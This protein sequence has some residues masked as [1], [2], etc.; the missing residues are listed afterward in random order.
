MSE[1]PYAP[2]SSQVA[3]I[4]GDTKSL[5]RPRLVQ[6]GIGL[7]AIDLLLGVVSLFSN[8]APNVLLNVL[9]LGLMGLITWLAWQG[10]N[11]ARIVH[12]V[13]LLLAVVFTTLAIM[14]LR[15]NPALSPG[16]GQFFFN[17]WSI[18]QNLL[19]LA[20]VILLFTPPANAWYRAM[21][22]ARLGIGT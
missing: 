15:A 18:A 2:P 20:G 3:D 8:G 5:E 10:R 12:L 11:W 14:A 17:A 4:E 22:A 16:A 21:K 19:N 7:L 13:V 9:I 1:N 6:V